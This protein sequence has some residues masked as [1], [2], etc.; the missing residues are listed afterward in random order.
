M[1]S[2]EPTPDGRCALCGDAAAAATVIAVDPRTRTAEVH[3]DGA[4]PSV[5]VALDLVEGVT[6]GDRVLVHQGFAI[7]VVA[8]A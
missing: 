7:G 4:P 8:R 3:L 1:E 5:T 6:P 2:C